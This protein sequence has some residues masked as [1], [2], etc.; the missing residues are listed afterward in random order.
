[1]NRVL[2]YF[3]FYFRLYERLIRKNVRNYDEI[4]GKVILKLRKRGAKVLDIGTGTGY[5]PIRL[6]LKYKDLV[7]GIDISEKMLS[8]GRE[9]AGKQGVSKLVHFHRVDAEDFHAKRGF[10]DFVTLLFMLYFTKSPYEI[11]SHAFN[12]LKRK[13][14][15]VI[16][17]AW[18]DDNYNKLFNLVVKA[19]SWLGVA[20][21]GMRVIKK[22]EILF[23]LEKAGFRNIKSEKVGRIR[24][25]ELF[26]V[27]A[28]KP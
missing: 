20:P 4:V 22:D 12:A 9:N 21:P 5:L 19:W 3:D 24:F 8:I 17:T 10:F 6:A 27:I 26:L 13:G 28:S 15:I 7:Y 14:K 18:R 1:M 23:M 16:V 25:F 11:I 2:N